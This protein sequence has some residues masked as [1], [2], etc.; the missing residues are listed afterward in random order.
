MCP[1]W[2]GK[3]AALLLSQFHDAMADAWGQWNDQEASS[4][5]LLQLCRNECQELGDNG[6]VIERYQQLRRMEKDTKIFTKL[7][8]CSLAV[9]NKLEA[10]GVNNQ[11]DV[12]VFEFRTQ[13]CRQEG[14]QPSPH[15]ILLSQSG[16][17]GG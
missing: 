14:V 2:A 15:G 13:K 6:T 1:G 4:T 5:S 16:H 17:D 11:E 9:R 3:K 12:D 8:D 10:I 7:A